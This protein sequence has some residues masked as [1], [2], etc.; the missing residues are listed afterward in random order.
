MPRP[1]RVLAILGNHHNQQ[2]YRC[3]RHRRP[4]NSS[5]CHAHIGF[6]PFLEIIINNRIDA[7]GARDVG[8]E[9]EEEDVDAMYFSQVEPSKSAAEAGSSVPRTPHFVICPSSPATGHPPLSSPVAG[10]SL[11]PVMFAFP[12]EPEEAAPVKQRRKRRG[13]RKRKRRKKGAKRNDGAGHEENAPKARS[14]LTLTANAGNV[15][16]ATNAPTLDGA[17][18]TKVEDGASSPG[19]G[20]CVGQLPR[21][22]ISVDKISEKSPDASEGRNSRQLPPGAGRTKSGIDHSMGSVHSSTKGSTGAAVTKAAPTSGESASYAVAAFA[23]L[24][25]VIFLVLLL[26]NRPVREAVVLALR[27][28]SPRP[29]S[30]PPSKKPPAHVRRVTKAASSTATTKK[31]RSFT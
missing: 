3:E 5:G 31:T 15:A 30:P 8:T 14:E 21:A 9:E 23:L 16:S 20:T 2:R 29:V 4:R 19:L 10:T 7:R 26:P 27:K 18:A 28:N 11:P 13:K 12:L 25:I 6:W 22:A 1:Q 24:S 17:P